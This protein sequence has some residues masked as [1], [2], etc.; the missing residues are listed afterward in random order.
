MSYNSNETNQ[1]NYISPES[2]ELNCVQRY[3]GNRTK[4]AGKFMVFIQQIPEDPN[5]DDPV[6]LRIHRVD[7]T[8]INLFGKQIRLSTQ[9]Y[10]FLFILAQ[11]PREP[12]DYKDIYKSVYNDDCEVSDDML[13]TIRRRLIK[14][15]REE[16]GTE[17]IPDNFIYRK[18]GE[19]Y[20][21]WLKKW[22][23]EII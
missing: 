12:V 13:Y 20:I 6:K 8:Y 3:Q 4:S 16:V 11:Y 22:Q 2:I 10:N 9:H 23:V 7:A 1:I 21:L 18:Q 15:L 14:K 19:G 5:I 17:N